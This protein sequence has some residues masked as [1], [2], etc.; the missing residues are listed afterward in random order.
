[1]RVRVVLSAVAAASL[2]GPGALPA[3]ASL[4]GP[5]A[6]PADAASPSW[7][8]ALRW[9][10]AASANFEVGRA[11]NRI[12]YI[13]I[14]ATDGRYAGSLAWF[15]DPRARLSSH[16][17]IRASDGEIAQAVTEADT[18][19]HARGFNRQSIGI[20]HEFDPSNGIGYTPAA[21]RS[22]ATLVCA[23]ARRYGIPLDRSHII[24]HNE[25]PNT[26]HADPG[27]TWDWTA[28]MSLVRS[29]GG[30]ARQSTSAPAFALCDERPCRPEPGLSTGDDGPDVAQLQWAL[31]YLG[32]L[33]TDD[34]AGGVGHFGPRTLGAL[35]GFQ[36][37]NGVPATGFYGDL[38]AAALEQALSIRPSDAPAV[39]LSVGMESVE[40]TRLQAALRA[41]GYMQLV[42][43]YFGSLTQEAVR[44]FQGD[45]QI[46]PTGY[47][48]PRTREALSLDLR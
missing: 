5:G 43:G 6:R 41:R 14:H 19:F 10:P 36:A 30:A 46:A 2:L 40:V 37:E 26:D 8:P 1:V 34:L 28:Y 22:S 3:D 23:I 13:V 27:P 20:E 12:A 31:V 15:Q 47:Y 9:V 33:A 45:H 17:V 18:A 39:D 48:G 25:V 4:L 7:Y 32:R 24:G 38:T 29:C 35:R 16:Y 21:Y 11:G 42:T 44:R